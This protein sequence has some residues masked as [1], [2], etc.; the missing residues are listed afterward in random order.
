MNLG[1][2]IGSTKTV[3][4]STKDQGTLIEDEFGAREI[5]TVLELTKPVRSFGKSASGDQLSNLKARRRFFLEN[6]LEDENQDNLFMFLN[7]LHRTILLRGDYKNACLAIPETFDEKQRQILKS[8]VLNSDIKVDAFLTHLT[9]VAAG[10]ALGNLQISETFMII[11][12]GYSKTSAGLFK[13]VD[14]KLTPIKRWAI[15]IGAKA[16]DDAIFSILIKNY[17]LPDSSITREKIYKD[18]SKTKRG[19]NDLQSVNTKILTES[20]EICNMTVNRDEYLQNLKPALEQLTEFF[21][22]VK[23]ESEF[24]G[25]VEVV[26]SNSNNAYIQNILKEISYNKT[27]NSSEA[28][29]HGACL[30]HGVNSR[31]MKFKVNEILGSEFTVKVE[32]EDVKPTVVFSDKFYS[33]KEIVKIKYMKKGSFNVEVFENGVKVGI[34]KVSKKETDSPEKIVI[35]VKISSFLTFEVESVEGGTD[36]TYV[37]EPN[38]L[39]Q[40]RIAQIKENDEG[41]RKLEV[42]IQ[43]I[44]QKRNVLENLLDSVDTTISKVFPG[45]ITPEDQNKIDEIRDSFFES[46]P[47]TTTI[48]QEDELKSSIL[49]KL[50]FIIEKIKVI[51]GTIRD[52]GEKILSEFDNKISKELTF[53]SA[54]LKTLNHHIYNLRGFLLSFSLNIE[55]ISRFDPQAFEKLKS[56]IHNAIPIARSEQAKEEAK[57]KEKAKEASCSEKCCNHSEKESKCSENHECCSNDCQHENKNDSHHEC[58]GENDCCNHEQ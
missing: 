57:S 29:A 39:T 58:C 5:P 25:Y 18:I 4:F 24:D 19:L 45:L 15:S 7:Y 55:N 20:Y 2:D 43:T 9:S 56:Q 30:A 37:Y 16:F 33:T 26:G 54:A 53:H 8:I 44:A 28:A 34:I 52:E 11:D 40:E 38:T 21:N 49:K 12:C 32:N 42:E 14:D 31:E 23:K 35:R 17:N 47:V 10:A 41:Y 27:L 6:I 46:S 36:M 13:F 1:I 51:E 48:E 22:T 50:T 3:I